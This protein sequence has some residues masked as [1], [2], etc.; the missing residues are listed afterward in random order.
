M[1]SAKSANL[2]GVW[3]GLYSYPRR[4]EPVSFTATLIDTAGVINGSSHEI[5]RQGRTAGYTLF[6]TLC[7]RHSDG[8]VAFTKT[9]DDGIPHGYAINYEGSIRDEGAEIEGLWTIPR[10][11]SG[12]FLMIRSAWNA[13]QVARK[14]FAR[15]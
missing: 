11:W 12:R 13:E 10:M 15:V 4:L 8:A 7:G 9:Y 14:K 5:P 6:A 2:T 3:L 1:C